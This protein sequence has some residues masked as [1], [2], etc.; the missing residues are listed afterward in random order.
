MCCRLTVTPLNPD[1]ASAVLSVGMFAPLEGI[2]TTWRRPIPEEGTAV[3]A[4]FVPESNSL[5]LELTPSV[6]QY[7]HH[8]EK[9]VASG[10]Y[11]EIAAKYAEKVGGRITQ[12][13]NVSGCTEGGVSEHVLAHYPETPLLWE[14]VCPGFR[15]TILGPEAAAS[16]DAA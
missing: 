10:V 8:A 2:S 15:E 1:V 12:L 13:S 6:S 3:N 9:R 14:Q 4:I 11:F 5:R 16:P 7:A